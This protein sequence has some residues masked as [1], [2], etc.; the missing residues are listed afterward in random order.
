M[1]QSTLECHQDEAVMQLA[2][3]VVGHLL[4]SHTRDVLPGFF[5]DRLC[6][7][8]GRLLG[9]A[10]SNNLTASLLSESETP[11][12]RAQLQVATAN[13]NMSLCKRLPRLLWPYS[14]L[15]CLPLSVAALCCLQA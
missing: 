7:C 4:Q 15:C 3:A 11:A 9:N 2:A 8:V 13:V 5:I 14:L 10:K 1:L 6:A 12:H